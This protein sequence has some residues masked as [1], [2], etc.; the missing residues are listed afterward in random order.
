MISLFIETGN[1]RAHVHTWFERS[2][3]FWSN[4]YILQPMFTF[5]RKRKPESICPYVVQ[6][7][8]RSIRFWSNTY[9]LQPMFVCIFVL[10]GEWVT[11]C[12]INCMDRWSFQL[13]LPA[14]WWH[15]HN[16]I[17]LSSAKQQNFKL[18]TTFELDGNF[19]TWETTLEF[20]SLVWRHLMVRPSVTRKQKLDCLI[21]SYQW[22]N[23]DLSAIGC[24]CIDHA[25][26]WWEH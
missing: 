1:Q 3:W 13:V 15:A 11:Y 25:S 9:I 18:S 2:I 24:N 6:C 7:W 8:E 23:G 4:T 14:S 17:P 21:M 12:H 20:N 19:I 26:F 10:L 22:S 16:F 5:Y